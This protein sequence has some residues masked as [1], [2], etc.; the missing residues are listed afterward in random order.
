M[1]TIEKHILDVYAE[2]KK[3]LPGLDC[4]SLG[5]HYYHHSGETKM[6]G[7]LH[8]GGECVQFGSVTEIPDYIKNTKEQR[9]GNEILFR[10]F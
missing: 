8:S 10:K 9:A 4:I 7:F 3:E 6:L 1:E 2:I 5:V